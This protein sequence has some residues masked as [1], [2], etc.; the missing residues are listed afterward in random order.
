MTAQ[1]RSKMHRKLFSLLLTAALLPILSLPALAAPGTVGSG[2]TDVS[3]SGPLDPLTGLPAGSHAD[4]DDPDY[5]ALRENVY[6]YDLSQKCYVNEVG[7]L[8]FTSSVP[9][10]SILS[11]GSQEISF[12]IPSGLSAVL[13]RNGNVVND[14]DLTAITD[15]G[16]YLL[17]VSASNSAESVSFSF[18][19]LGRLTGSVTE[20]SLPAGFSFDSVLLNGE[21]LSTEYSNYTQLLEDGRYEISWSCPEISRHYSVTFTLDTVAPT[22]LLPEVVNGEAHSAVTLTDLEENAYVLLTDKKTGET[23]TILYADTEIADA[24]T[25]HLAVYDRAGN[26]TDYDFTIHV[27]LNISALAA[28]VLALSGIAGLAAYSRHIRKHPRVG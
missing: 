12:S 4:G 5:I 16:N 11:A 21:S 2:T 20:F 26:H 28:I 15:E 17:E 10:G 18:R 22:L 6:G 7:S 23:S 25:Y 14:A 9:N 24:G 8:S 1:R 27:Y 3:Y 13:Y 19:L